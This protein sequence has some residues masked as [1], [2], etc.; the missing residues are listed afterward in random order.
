MSETQDN[1]QYQKDTTRYYADE[2]P[3]HY[4]KLTAFIVGKYAIL[5]VQ[6]LMFSCYGNIICICRVLNNSDFCLILY[7]NCCNVAG[8]ICGYR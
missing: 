5:I 6:A 4:V 8:C 2:G 3:V 7:N 1:Y